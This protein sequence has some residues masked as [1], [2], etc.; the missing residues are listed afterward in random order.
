MVATGA[1]VANHMFLLVTD[2]RLSPHTCCDRG[3]RIQRLL[4]C[5]VS[6]PACLSPICSNRRISNLLSDSI[7][8][9][10]AGRS[11]QELRECFLI[12]C[13]TTPWYWIR[14]SASWNQTRVGTY[15]GQVPDRKSS[16]ESKPYTAI[17][18]RGDSIFM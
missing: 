9:E 7:K 11:T 14:R 5:V 12:S 3:T 13:D 6:R 4:P 15:I 17:M 10:G 8:E 2:S 18:F 16:A 1:V